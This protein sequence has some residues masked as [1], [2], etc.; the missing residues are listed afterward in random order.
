MPAL[1]D[2]HFSYGLQT[3][4]LPIIAVAILVAKVEPQNLHIKQL[5][6]QANYSGNANG[7][8]KLADFELEAAALNGE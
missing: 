5:W 6:R 4:L 1:P 3:A 2:F 8:E 7:V